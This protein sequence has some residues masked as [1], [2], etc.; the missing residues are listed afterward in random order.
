MNFFK[1]K[2]HK[3]NEI[4]AKY[5]NALPSIILEHYKF[6]MPFMLIAFL[7]FSI[8]DTVIWNYPT[9]T[10][11]RIPAIVTNLLMIIITYTS[12]NQRNKLVITINNVYS[13]SL[14]FMAF[15]LVIIGFFYYKTPQTVMACIM[16]IVASHFFVKGSKSIILVYTIGLIIGLIMLIFHLNKISTIESQYLVNIIIIFIGV[17][18]L[19]LKRESRRYSE[20]YY[21]TEF[22]IEKDKNHKL[23]LQ[24]QQ[25]NKSLK[26]VNQQL[27]ETLQRLKKT[28]ATKSK[29][30]SLLAHDLR[31]PFTTLIGHSKLL[32]E[33]M[34]SFTKDDIH[35][36]HQIILDTSERTYDLLENLLHWSMAQTGDLKTHPKQWNIK[37]LLDEVY[38]QIE[39]CTINKK[40]KLNFD[41]SVQDE[42]FAD[43]EVFK[44]ICR[45]IISNAIKFSNINDHI[46]IVVLN[47]KESATVKIIDNG[48]GIDDETIYSLMSNKNV[49]SKKGTQNEKGTGI[50]LMLCRDLMEK[51]GGNIS[52][53]KNKP[54]GTIVSL[55]FPRHIINSIL[56][57]NLQLN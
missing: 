9:F 21:K 47:N 45:N 11:F 6:L 27:D 33:E 31:H 20:F 25:Q 10:L 44:I 5:N 3:N 49:T 8:T 53:E 24:T 38:Y 56:T 39:G 34:D 30:F 17:V 46:N 18:V 16:L 36:Q 4:F 13:I 52:F 41:V 50:G 54:H 26:Q 12:L 15:G 32:V 55:T 43:S 14:L 57:N 7:Y 51:S 23:Y 22:S 1:R 42:V 29:L 19:S 40:I 28:N 35:K 37:Q 2:F 48:V